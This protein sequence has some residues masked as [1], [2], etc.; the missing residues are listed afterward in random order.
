[1]LFGKW[2]NWHERR[3]EKSTKK[4]NK[5]RIACF[6]KRALTVI[7]RKIKEVNNK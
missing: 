2:E 7:W 4:I 1:M 3:T 6:I 5:R